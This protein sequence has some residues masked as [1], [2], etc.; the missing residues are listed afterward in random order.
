MYVNNVNTILSFLHAR[1]PPTKLPLSSTPLVRV[2]DTGTAPRAY[3]FSP[4]HTTRKAQPK[5]DMDKSLQTNLIPSE[6]SS[7][8]DTLNFSFQNLV[9]RHHATIY[10]QG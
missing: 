3:R 8:F 5:L 7:L 9:P 2:N 6:I 4:V 1:L 10:R